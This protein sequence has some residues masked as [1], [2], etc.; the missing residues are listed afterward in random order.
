MQLT[1]ENNFPT[2]PFYGR[3][4]GKQRWIL[5]KLPPKPSPGY[6]TAQGKRNCSRKNVAGKH[7]EKSPPEPEKEAAADCQHAARKQ[8]N[9]TNGEKEWIADRAPGAPLH[10]PLLQRLDKIGNRKKGR[11]H[12][13]QR[14]CNRQ[15][16]ELPVNRIA[17]FEHLEIVRAS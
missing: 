17:N 4:Q 11:K 6:P 2:L 16:R 12:R 1:Q 5:R 14:D 7:D 9:V 3:L 15:S 13:N 10:H 8:E